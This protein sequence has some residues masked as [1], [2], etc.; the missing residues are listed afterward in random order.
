M[1]V[2]YYV[3]RIT[4][5][6][7]QAAQRYYYGMRRSTVPPHLDITYWSS[8]KTLHQAIKTFGQESFH[9]KIIA[10]YPTREEA[11][12]LEMKFHRFFNVKDH[13]LFFNRANQTSVRFQTP[14]GPLSHEHREA[15][16]RGMRARYARMTPAERAAPFASPD[17]RAKLS[18]ANKGKARP[19]EVRAKIAASH[20]GR[21]KSES[22]REALRQKQ[23]G[24]KCV[25]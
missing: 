20:R 3:Y 4:C 12:A 25:Q 18:A 7:P 9:K 5:T 21:I 11:L 10:V 23:T 13:P 22:H 17:L 8:S 14:A 1:N 2:F 16:V 19:E 6:H 24:K 15:M